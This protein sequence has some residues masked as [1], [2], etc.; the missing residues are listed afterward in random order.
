MDFDPGAGVDNHSPIST[1]DVF[2]VKLLPNGY[3]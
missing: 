2:L 1:V 3:W